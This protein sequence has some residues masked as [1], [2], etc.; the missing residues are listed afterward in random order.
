MIKV[1]IVDDSASVRLFLEQIFSADPGI[2]VVGTAANGQEAIAAVERLNPDVVTMDIYM[3]LMNGLDATRTIMENH[4]VPI[5][6]VSGN[7]DPEEV[8]TSFRAMEAGALVAL[9][10]PRGAG[11]PDHEREVASLVLMVKLMSEIKV[12]KRWPRG[13]K[14][15]PSPRAAARRGAEAAGQPQLVAIGASTGGPMAIQ[16]VLTG[17]GGHFP[18]PVLIVQH[19]APGF[20]RGFAEWLAL[21]SPLPV[22]VACHGELILP[23]RAYV[24]PDGFHLLVEAG[25]R[26]RL[27]GGPPDNGLRP[28]VSSLFRSVAEVYGRNAAGVLL[29][30]M[31]RDGVDELL[32]LKQKG[33]VTIAQDQASSVVY[34]MPA[35]AVRIGAADYVLPPDR[36]AATLARLTNKPAWNQGI[37][38]GNNG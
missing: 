14:A 31:G 34:G 23:G 6:I 16:T 1:L 11:H 2:R 13:G 29:T 20:V 12:V 22:R 25:G 21:T 37:T 35:E 7:L 4:P 9:A 38:A 24:A 3:P 8:L 26:L 27:G 18:V 28:S 19:M 32:L 17:L 5:V 33:A 30:G 36:I 10:K 15:L